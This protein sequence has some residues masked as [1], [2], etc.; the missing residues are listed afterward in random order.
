MCANA[1]CSIMLVMQIKLPPALWQ[2]FLVSKHKF[3]I[4]GFVSESKFALS[5]FTVA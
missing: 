2:P 3:S 5:V 4:K 1:H